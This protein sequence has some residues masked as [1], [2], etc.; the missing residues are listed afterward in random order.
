MRNV[1]LEFGLRGLPYV[2]QQAV[3]LRYKGRAIGTDLRI[4]LLV[5]DRVVVELKAVEKLLPIHEAQILTYLRLTGKEIGL[6]INF[7]VPLLKGGIRRFLNHPPLRVSV[8]PW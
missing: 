2:R 7:N 6:L 3:P 5:A 8:P 1:W 4:D